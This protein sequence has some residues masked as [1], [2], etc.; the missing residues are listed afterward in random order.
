MPYSVLKAIPT[1][2]LVEELKGREG[3]KALTVIPFEACTVSIG[4]GTGSTKIVN[5]GP[6]VIL[7]I[8]D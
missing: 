7:A 3:V 5:M 8:E 4:V 1:A 2:K 6:L